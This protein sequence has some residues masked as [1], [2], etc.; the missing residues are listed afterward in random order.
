MKMKL[1]I[2][3]GFYSIVVRDENGLVLAER[4]T[5]CNPAALSQA[6]SDAE[7]IG[8]IDWENSQYAKPEAAER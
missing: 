3:R 5:T 6:I 2:D 8:E 4:K 7:A 1:T